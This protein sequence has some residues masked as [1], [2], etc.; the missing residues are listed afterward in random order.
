MALSKLFDISSRSLTAYQYALSVTSQNISNANNPNFTRRKVVLGEEKTDRLVN[1]TLGSGVKIE[2]VVRVKNQIV[3]SQI[4]NYNQNN[5]FAEKQTTILSNLETLLAEPSN[6]GLSSLMT[7]FFNSWNELAVNPNS[8]QLR[9]KVVQSAQSMT[10][11]FQ[12]LYENFNEISRDVKAEAI[13]SVNKINVLVAQVQRLNKD[14]FEA[15]VAG[16][17]PHDLLDERDTAI[18]ELSK[19]AN[20][21]V[22]TDKN[23]LLSLSIGGVFA[24]DQINKTQFKVE[25]EG[26][27]LYVKTVDGSVRLNL[28]GGEVGSMLKSFSEN[29]SSYKNTLD[30]VARA[31]YESVNSIHSQAYTL[32]NPPQNGIS[33]FESYESGVLKINQQLVND[34][35]LIAVSADGTSGNNYFALRLA[36]LKDKK[37]VN[38]QTIF[39]KYSNFVS[40]LGN[41]IN[42][43][44]QNAES[45]NLV[46]T[47]LE[48]QKTSYSG[49]SIDEEM[50]N[51]IKFQRSFDAAAKLIKIADDLTQ[52]IL[53]IVG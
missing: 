18:N 25:E 47:Q 12:S 53:N 14:I 11:K 4:R 16:N 3:E 1:M 2:D 8:I 20:I 49:V 7:S 50:T 13:E 10:E 28:T 24:A 23:G 31:I 39:D 26:G 51:I 35:N 29:I 52:T 27:K 41:E 42:L 22:H 36:E 5:S 45:Y 34:P 21:N 9:S 43:N 6:L 37:L 38:N 40:S 46:L 48:N 32:T 17:K 44:S 33:F 30:T 19:M 15:Q